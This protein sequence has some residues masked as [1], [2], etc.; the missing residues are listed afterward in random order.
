MLWLFHN[1][2]SRVKKKVFRV[3]IYL[4]VIGQILKGTI[5]GLIFFIVLLF[6]V[7]IVMNGKIFD[8]YLYEET[9]S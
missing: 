6:S 5:M 9:L 8:T 2:V 3:K 7:T 1:C 4:T